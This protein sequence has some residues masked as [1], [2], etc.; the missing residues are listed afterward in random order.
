MNC[1]PVHLFFTPKNEVNRHAYMH[2]MKDQEQIMF[3]KT[4]NKH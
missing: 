4:Q 3:I 1:T 2:H